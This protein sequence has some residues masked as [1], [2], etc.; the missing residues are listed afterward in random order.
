MTRQT[1]YGLILLIGSIIGWLVS[2]A[3]VLE[4]IALYKDPNHVASCD[5]NTFVSCTDV[6]KTPQAGLF[7]FPNPFL[8][9]VAFA[10]AITIGVLLVSGVKLPRWFMIGLQVGITVGLGFI[11]FFWSQSL[12]VIGALCPYCMV[13]WSVVIPMFIYTTIF[14]MQESVIFKRMRASDIEGIRSWAW[15]ILLVAYIGIAASI[16]FRFFLG[17]L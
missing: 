16:L 2:G 13:V 10:V 7:G 1:K 11:V 3:L 8:G 17:Y 4:R 6:M 9:I 5:V 14:N 15:V 12:Y